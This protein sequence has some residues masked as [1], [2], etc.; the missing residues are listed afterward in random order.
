[1]SD[2]FDFSVDKG[3]VECLGKTFQNDEERRNYFTELLREKLKDPEFR[4][5]EGFPLGEDE[6]ILALSDP[7]YYTACPNPWMGEFIEQWEQEKPTKQEGY[8]Y[9]RE[10]FA[11]DVS[12]GKNDPIY[13]AHSY[14]TKVPHKAIMRYILHYTEPGDIVFDGFCGT[15]MTGV[16]AQM[17]GDIGTVQSLGYRVERDGTILQE[18]TDEEGKNVWKPFSKLGARKAVLND[19]SPAATFIAYNYNIPVDIV[20]FE[21][22]AK[23]ILD[24][25]EE[26]CG[27]MYETIHTDGKTKGKINY[28]VWSDVFVCPSCVNEVVF[29]NEAVDQKAGKV[30]DSFPCPHCHAEMTKQN[31]DRAW[32]TFYDS[33]LNENIKQAKQ[34]PV[35]INYSINGYKGRFEKKP[36]EFDYELIEKI[37]QKEIPYWFPTNRLPDGY[38]TRQPIRSH[39]IT[40]MHHFYTKRNLW[41]LASIYNRSNPNFYSSQLAMWWTLTKLYRYRWAGGVPGAGGGPMAGTLYIPSII[42]DISVLFSA[43]DVFN[44]SIRK[45]KL[46]SN[47]NFQPISTQSSE[48]NKIKNDTLDYIFIDPPFGS[49]LNYS[50]LSSLWE[51]WLKIMTNNTSEA[52]ENSVQEKGPAEYRS[53]MT[54][55]FK[56]A[57]RLLK[58]GRWMTVE[59]SNTKASVWNTIQTA[60]TDAGFIVSNVA[61]LDKKQGSIKAVTTSTAVKKDLVISAY[62]PNG[63]FE[64]RFIKEANSEDGVW[65]FIG[66]HLKYLIV[67]KKSGANL[68]HI[69]ERDPRILYDQLISYYVRKGYN[70]PLSSQEF[71]KGLA[72]RFEERD[73]MFFL[74]DQ[75]VE[76]DKARAKFSG[77]VQLSLFVDDEKSAIDWLRDY[78]K[79]KPGTY[80]DIHP[81][82]MQ[83]MS[84][85]SWKAGE[86]QP[87]L[88]DLLNLNF[89]RYDGK[90]EVPSQIHSYLSTNFKDLRKLDK[91]D[92]ALKAKAKDRWYVPDPNKEADLEKVRLKS[93]LKEYEGYKEG[94]GKLKEVRR[95]ALRAGF[96]Q[97]YQNKNFNNIML[98][99]KRLK[100]EIIDEDETLLMYFDYASMVVED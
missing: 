90:D 32:E 13:N 19:L 65:D 46:L 5:I 28:T 96:K 68:V 22:E 41:T 43:K 44:K 2:Q 30:K 7:P 14:H 69:P 1:M 18:E 15:G 34:V 82:F 91:N 94:K 16:A 31:M 66:T 97:D 23:R 100:P 10:P 29:W 64:D 24:E 21:R 54:S 95:E 20:Q 76:Y 86:K 53:I 71:Q 25:V 47:L 9:H 62:K 56:E 74:H 38:N 83:Q 72:E 33:A 75:V 6:D 60:L 48:N 3:P 89:L 70:I 57:Y 67:T 88:Q 80:S 73:D 39:G 51:S 26:E 4:S 11:A 55:C 93:L 8:K 42:K 92:E 79:R 85:N 81:N 99:A 84:A 52:I 50:E 35:L 45:K 61:G 59:F 36:D 78:L 17:C 63:G 40:H 58:P 77:Q 87:E 12:E 49:N 98:I 27:W 37:D